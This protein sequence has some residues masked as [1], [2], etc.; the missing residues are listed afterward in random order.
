MA[1]RMWLEKPFFTFWFSGDVPG[2]F[3]F[4]WF[5]FITPAAGIFLSRFA[6][7][8]THGWLAPTLGAVLPV[9]TMWT[10]PFWTEFSGVS[11]IDDRQIWSNGHV[12]VTTGRGY[13][14]GCSWEHHEK[15]ERVAGS[16]TL[17]RK[18][19]ALPAE[20]R[21][22]FPHNLIDTL[23]RNLLIM[24]RYKIN[25]GIAK[26]L[27]EIDERNKQR[28]YMARRAIPTEDILAA[29]ERAHEHVKVDT[30]TLK[31]FS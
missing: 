5:V 2:A 20:D 6:N 21:A 11:D 1:K 23:L 10:L 15:A 29:L 30:D 12:C 17:Y 4:S 26:A 9:A 25:A 31:E 24:E 22:L 19:M 16:Q 8:H 13:S 18:V 7:S 27:T 3:L 14:D 28:E